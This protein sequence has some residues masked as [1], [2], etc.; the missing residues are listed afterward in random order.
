MYAS[1]RSKYPPLV[2][3]GRDLHQQDNARPHTSC[4]T[5]EK[6]EELEGIEFLPHPVYSANLAPSDYH[7]SRSMASFFR[8]RRFSNIDEL[9][10]SCLALRAAQPSFSVFHVQFK[11]S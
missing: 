1:L 4:I 3:R 11:S 5:R 8:E 6:I 2:N 9:E 7:M 10:R